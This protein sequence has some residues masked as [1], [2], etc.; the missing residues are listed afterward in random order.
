MEITTTE[1]YFIFF[2]WGE[3]PGDRLYSSEVTTFFGQG[4]LLKW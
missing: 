2:F 1:I 3:I 4:G